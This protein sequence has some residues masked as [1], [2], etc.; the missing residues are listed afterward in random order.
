MNSLPD[1]LFLNVSDVAEL[2]FDYLTELRDQVAVPGLANTTQERQVVRRLYVRMFVTL[3]EGTIATFKSKVLEHPTNLNEC[4]RA[5]LRDIT[6]DL[7]DKG[8]PF[9]RALHP[10]LLSSIKFAFRML[11]RAYGLKHK[12]DYSLKGW[13]DLQEVLRIRNR[14][15]HPKT[16]EQ[17]RVTAAE[18]KLV[19]SAELWFRQSHRELLEQ[20]NGVL[21]A[22][23]EQLKLR[24][25]A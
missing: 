1:D 12:P 17:M 11:S 7:N 9:E 15:T 19:D 16:V 22:K 14:L 6:Y 13:Q 8:D 18:L 24:D 21:S 20:Y 23:L 10:P 5:V 4:E 2:D 25:G 3:L